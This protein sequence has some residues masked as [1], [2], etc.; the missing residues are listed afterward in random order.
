MPVASNP[1]ANSVSALIFDTGGTV[2][3]WHGGIADA[4]ERIGGEFGIAGDWLALTREW[5]RLSTGMVNDGLPSDGGR[6]TL[7]M[8]DVLRRT[9]D[10]ML[11]RYGLAF[12]E[13]A[14]TRL[15]R[16]WHD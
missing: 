11:A 9:L 12:P 2:F 3:D 15:V 10:D 14:R 7:D 1:L 13:E 16:A 6:A 5:R 4:L 8:D